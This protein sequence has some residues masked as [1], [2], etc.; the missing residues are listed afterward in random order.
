MAE[1]IKMKCLTTYLLI[2]VLLLSSCAK[3]KVETT[4][5]DNGDVIEKRYYDKHDS[6]SKIIRYYDRNPSLEF[7]VTFKESDFDSIIY[8]YDNGKVFKTGKRDLNSQLLGTWNLFD[9]DGNKREIREFFIWNGKAMLN[10]AWFLDKK[11]DTIAWR[12]EDDVFKQEEFLNDT[13]TVRHTSYNFFRFN[14]DTVRLN[15]PIRGVAYCFSPMLE[16]YDSEIRIIVDSENERFNSDFS[17]E[18]DI[19]TQVFMNLE[20]DTS[21]QKWITNIKKRDWKYTAVFG[22][23]FESSGIKTIRG[24]MEE[25]AIGP[26]KDKDADSITSRTFFEKQVVVL[27]SI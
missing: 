8:F 27:D 5:N 14:K 25:F 23:W 2:L 4:L 15:E 24:Y 7:K 6:L 16:D 9:R 22:N 3:N 17:N 20:K 1:I 13:L 12:Y 18:D 10:R 19:S 26:F 21:N 11:G